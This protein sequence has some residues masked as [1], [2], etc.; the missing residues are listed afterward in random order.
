MRMAAH[1]AVC[2]DAELTVVHVEEIEAKR[3]IGDLCAWIAE[4]ERPK[5]TVED[6][7]RQGSPAEEILQLAHATNTDLLVIGAEHKAFF[8]STVLGSTT[9]RVVRH[10]ACPVLTVAEGLGGKDVV[11]A[12]FQQAAR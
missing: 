12:S 7:R 3:R 11:S 2:F 5:C 6:L 9:L 4:G 10:A 8:D 1:L